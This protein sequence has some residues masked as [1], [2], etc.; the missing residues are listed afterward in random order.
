VAVCLL[1]ASCG[2]NT[3]SRLPVLGD[4][5]VGPMTVHIRKEISPKSAMVATLTHGDKVDVLEQRRI[6]ARVRTADGHE[7]WTEVKQL[8]TREQ[9]NELRA[10]TEQAATLASQGAAV[11]YDPVNMHT[12]PDRNSPSFDQ[13][14]EGAR[15]EVLAHKL[16]P[17]LPRSSAPPTRLIPARPKPEKKKPQDDDSDGRRRFRPPAAPAPGLPADWQELSKSGET[18]APVAPTPPVDETPV[19]ME[20]WTL[21]RTK[22]GAAGWVLTRMLEMAIPD[23]VAQYSEGHRITAY[24][25]MAEVRDGDKV[26]YDWLWT[27]QSQTDVP[28]DFD[29]FRYFVW[30][31][32]HHRYETGYIQ[33]NVIGYY[34]V[35]V[36]PGA[37]PKFSMILQDDDGKVY[38]D[39]FVLQG[40]RVHLA[41]KQPWTPPQIGAVTQQSP[42]PVRAEVPAGQPG[43]FERLRNKIHGWMN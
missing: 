21:V 1:L 9:M 29:S 31:T 2:P 35:K 34:P 8:M 24:F 38:R 7:G 43:L 4:A 10:L 26:K 33:R 39:D 30:S 28:Y 3:Q 22:E 36:T 13:F 16:A 14:R 37:Q 40:Y 6:F 18:D 42:A 5:F 12:A 32:R 41:N 19:P 15:V 27:T 17:R 11:S 20:D 23:E 25:A